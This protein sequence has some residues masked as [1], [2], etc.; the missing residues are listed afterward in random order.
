MNT[1]YIWQR[2]EIISMMRKRLIFFYM[3]HNY[4]INVNEDAGVFKFWFDE[5]T[6]KKMHDWEEISGVF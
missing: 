2:N 4:Y 5:S 1:P 3:K 6:A